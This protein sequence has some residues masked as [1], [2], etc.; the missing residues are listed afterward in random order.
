MEEHLGAWQRG[1]MLPDAVEAKKSAKAAK[2]TGAEEPT[3]KEAKAVAAKAMAGKAVGVIEE[4][5]E[6]EANPSPASKRPLAERL[7]AS[8]RRR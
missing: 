3:A 2:A 5:A 1:D 6:A 4:P 7:A 8:K